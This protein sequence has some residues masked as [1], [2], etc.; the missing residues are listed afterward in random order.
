MKKG[1]VWWGRKRQPFMDH[2]PIKITNAH[3][4]WRKKKFHSQPWVHIYIYIDRY[5]RRGLNQSSVRELTKLCIQGGKGELSRWD[6][7]FFLLLHVVF[8]R[9]VLGLCPCGFVSDSIET[10]T[11]PVLAILLLMFIRGKQIQNSWQMKN[12]TNKQTTKEN[13]HI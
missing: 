3:G 1:G 7:F 10:L 8:N 5:L 9:C 4:T 12:K 2:R 6:S 11:T 13:P